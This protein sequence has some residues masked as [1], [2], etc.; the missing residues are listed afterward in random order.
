MTAGRNRKQ[1]RCQSV[2]E[3]QQDTVKNLQPKGG[4][5]LTLL[6]A[7]LVNKKMMQKSRKITETLAHG[8]SSES[9]HY[10]ASAIKWIPTWQGLVGFQKS[11]RFWTKVAWALEGLTEVSIFSLIRSGRYSAINHNIMGVGVVYL[12]WVYIFPLMFLE[13]F[14]SKI[15]LYESDKFLEHLIREITY[16]S[17]KTYCSEISHRIF[18]MSRG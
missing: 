18:Y 6:E 8:Y 12:D 2:A 4:L 15:T 5:T 16:S 13:K 14:N 10:S 1:A 17:P 3:K 7:N 11:L 9:T